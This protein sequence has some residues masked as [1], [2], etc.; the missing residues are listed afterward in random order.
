MMRF[1]SRRAFL[2]TVGAAAIAGCFAEESPGPRGGAGDGSD[3]DSETPASTSTPDPDDGPPVAE[4]TYYVPY[5]VG[6]LRSM[7]T[8]TDVHQ[9]GIPSIDDP[10]FTDA[11]G[12]S[13]GTLDLDDGDV[14]FGVERGGVAKA[15]PQRVVVYHEIVNDEL[16]GVPIALT[17]CPLT[18]TAQGFERGG[19]TFGVSGRL[20][21]SNLVLFDRGTETWWPQ[22]LGYGL[23]PPFAGVSLRE[24]RVIWTTWR[25]WRTAHPD[26]LVMTADTGYERRYH[27]DP[28]G[29]Y[30]PPQGYY[31]FGGPMYEVAVETDGDPFEDKEVVLGC[32]TTDGAAAFHKETVLD[33]RIVR[34]EIGGVD[35]VA[36]A[37]P[38]LASGYVYADPASHSID[39]D[40]DGYRLDGE[41]YEPASLPLDRQLAFD[42]MWFAWYASYPDTAVEY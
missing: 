27:D 17:Y 1:R 23:S 30:N 36:V 20:I 33:E 18:G 15:Y 3:S 37:D 42:A 24:F 14:V 12:I 9:D 4:E 10:T 19:T 25:R 7:A 28:Y 40:G 21:N 31:D 35:H 8:M 22:I 11:D 2:G 5:D 29:G 32:R 38:S 26:T 34:A 13:D 6:V 39:P 16:A 41:R